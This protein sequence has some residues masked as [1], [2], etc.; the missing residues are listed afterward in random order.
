M[1]LAVNNVIERKAG[2][3][4][5]GHN[6][7]YDV[8]CWPSGNA[9]ED[10]GA[11]INS[12]IAH[13][14]E[15]QNNVQHGINLSEGKPGAVIYIPPGDYHL[16]T[17][18]LVDISYLRIEGSGHG[19][20][21]SSIRFNTE[22]SALREY[23]DI[24]PGGSRILVDLEITPNEATSNAAK[25]AAIFVKRDGLPRISSVEFVGFC[26]D[27]LHFT[28]ADGQLDENSY[29]NGKTGI[30]VASANDSFCLRDMGFIYLEHGAVL[31]ESDALTIDNNFIAEC[32]NCVELLDC[33]QAS[34]ISNNLMGAGFCGHTIYAENFGGLLISSNNIFPRGRSSIHLK[35]VARSNI[36]S[37]RLHSFYAGAIILEGNCCE[38]LVSSN[39]IL[40]DH[41]P[42]APMQGYNNG[43][44]DDYGVL[45]VEG[46][47]NSI[48]S[49]H[50]SNSIAPEFLHFAKDAP[51]QPVIIR[52]AKGTG[53]FISQNH[54]VATN[55]HSETH[56]EKKDA[57]ASACFNTQVEAILSI[58]RLQPFDE[59]IEL[60]IDEASAMNTCLYTSNKDKSRLSFKHNVFVGLPN[61]NSIE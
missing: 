34:K 43:I 6:N 40:R 49:N 51:A 50:I 31:H 38:N 61:L 60:Q 17:Q 55:P 20:I 28:T 39:H 37:N 30:M 11:V 19:F 21:S 26:I 16:K 25:G 46:N 4:T 32:G 47:K 54:I 22:S 8:T 27:G 42:W 52:I 41:E 2:L 44:T 36:T 15:K 13:V 7:F 58:N 18:I 29:L 53:N 3:G 10:I 56:E 48:M 5:I 24:W 1:S 33:G 59:V 35:N 45:H 9:Y 14:K 23:R 12:I 57:E